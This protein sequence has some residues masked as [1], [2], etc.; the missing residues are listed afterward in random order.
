MRN[1]FYYNFSFYMMVAI[2]ATVIAIAI[3]VASIA[4]AVTAG[5]S[6]WIFV[7]IICYL[8]LFWLATLYAWMHV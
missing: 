5:A 6:P 2:I 1:W 8:S 4:I 3:S 7:S